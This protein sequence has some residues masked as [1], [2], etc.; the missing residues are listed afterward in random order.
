MDK[1][2]KKG[3]RVLRRN[4][5][6]GAY[7]AAVCAILAAVLVFLNLIV[8]AIPDDFTSFDLTANG[9]YTIGDAT[10][11]VLEAVD[12]DIAIYH[13]YEESSATTDEVINTANLLEDYVRENS[14]IKVQHVDPGV[15]PT[16]LDQYKEKDQQVYD[17]S[18]VVDG[19]NRHIIVDAEDLY[20]YFFNGEYLTFAEFYEI[21]QMYAMYGSSIPYEEFFFAEQEITSAINYVTIAEVPVVYVTSGHGEAGLAENFVAAIEGENITV[22]TLNK[23]ESTIPEDAESVIIS[24]PT[25]DFSEEDVKALTDYMNAGGDVILVT[26][27]ATQITSKLPNLHSMCQAMGLESVEGVIVEED[28]DHYYSADYPYVL[29]PDINATSVPAQY[30]GATNVRVGLSAS[31]GISIS[32][33][34]PYKTTAVLTTSDKAFVKTDL[35]DPS[36]AKKDEY[37]TGKFNLGVHVSV[38]EKPAAENSP[39]TSTITT[40]PETTEPETVAPDTAGTDTAAPVTETETTGTVSDTEVSASST[41]SKKY[42]SFTWYSSAD[43][44]SSYYINQGNGYMFIG[45][46]NST[47]E[48][49]ITPIS[50][51]GKSLSIPFADEMT[52]TEAK[53]YSII[54]VAVIPLAVVIS[55]IS[56]WAVRRRK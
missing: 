34:A 37:A 19:P 42:G 49:S 29:Y 43:I 11:Q 38:G 15:S 24:A 56:V 22:T 9:M 14:H 32:K 47:C 53:T 23:I 25:T 31:H 30:M 10:K 3:E 50:I 48:K 4:L 16:F 28:K 40:A 5:R 13:I 27:Y 41:T 46:V 20:R 12:T 35:D 2:F 33:T 8:G 26:S 39:T 18:L 21:Y 54:F 52:N 44:N 7:T 45:T 6:S 1:N 36:F 55:G 51:I 17:N